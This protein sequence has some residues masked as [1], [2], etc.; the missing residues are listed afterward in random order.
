MQGAFWWCSNLKEVCI[1]ADQLP[2]LSTNLDPFDKSGIKIYVNEPLFETLESDNVWKK[3]EIIK[4]EI[5]FDNP[6]YRLTVGSVYGFGY[7]IQESSLL[8]R[9]VSFSSSNTSIFTYTD[10]WDTGGAFNIPGDFINAKMVGT[11]SLTAQG[12]YGLKAECPVQV[13]YKPTDMFIGYVENEMCIGDTME[14]TTIPLPLGALVT[15]SWTSENL[16]V[17]EVKSVSD[18]GSSAVIEAV[19]L[20]EAI[21]LARDNDFNLS[22]RCVVKVLPRAET[23][24]LEPSQWNGEEG[25]SF[26]ITATIT[27]ENAINK[28]LEWSSSNET[29]A[30]VD[31]TGL[32]SVLKEGECVIT[33]KTTDGSDLTANCY[34]SATSGINN[35]SF[36]TDETVDVYSL[37]GVK[38]RTNCK[39][40]EALNLPAGAY[41]LRKGNKVEKLIIR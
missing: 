24:N 34:L 39:K 5:T 8:S 30:T 14:L 19:G 23:L 11:A 7:R 22:A 15:P 18:N 4:R 35:I 17:A 37:D 13:Y 27:P 3:Q 36:D 21:I 41:L 40:N 6:E 10:S 28:P 29:V 16:E 20:G 38:V 32:V 2:S 31:E 12:A 1:L 33:A 26:Q 9:K 25:D